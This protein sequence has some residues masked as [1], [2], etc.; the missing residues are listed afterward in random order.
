VGDLALLL[1][2]QRL[3]IGELSARRVSKSL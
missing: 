1:V 2:V 3:L